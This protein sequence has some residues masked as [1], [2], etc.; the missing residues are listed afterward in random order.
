MNIEFSTDVV[1]VTLILCP[2]LMFPGARGM[3]GPLPNL[4]G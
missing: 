1:M 4:Y 3:E 2:G